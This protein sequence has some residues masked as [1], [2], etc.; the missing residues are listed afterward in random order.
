MFNNQKI[1]FRILLGYSVPL[2]LFIMVTVAVYASLLKYEKVHVET[3]RTATIDEL[4]NELNFYIVKMQR[5]VRGNILL[6]SEAD[7]KSYDDAAKQIEKILQTLSTL[8]KDETQKDKIARIN[9]KAKLLHD[10]TSKM[11][12]LV[13]Q[14]EAGKA[15]E[16]YRSGDGKRYGRELIDISDDLEKK[17]E[18]L[19]QSWKK[20]EDSALQDILLYLITGIFLALS[21]TIVIALL[22]TKGITKHIS[23][24]VSTMSSTSTEIAVTVN[25]HERTASQQASMVNETTTTVQELGVSSRQTAE[26]ASSAAEVAQNSLAATAEGSTIVRQA[27]D[28]MKSLGEKVGILADQT[29]RLGEQTAQIAGMATLVKDLS[30]EINMLAL[31]AAVE[32]ARAGEHGRGFAVVAGEVRKLANESKKSA[33]QVNA[34]IAE[35]QKATNAT[36]L[37]TEEGTRM[38]DEVTLYT[39]NVGELFDSLSESSGRVYENA[40]QVLL[41]ARQQSTAIGQIV[42]AMNGLNSGA[43]ETAAGIVQTKAGIDQLNSAAGNL[44]Q[45]I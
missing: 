24:V 15:A 32:A 23:S 12:L 44:K 30:S 31:N 20:A 28:G 27:I 2:V 11:F 17:E 19:H 26:Q 1:R 45:I 34:V 40:Q 13:D 25:Q 16:I 36:I 38:V 9:E 5:D 18:I 22:I 43:R 10:F 37:K 7:R 41:N 35:I 33:E 14:G 4:S 8:V 6:K 3:N 29:L 39:R 42:E 21:I